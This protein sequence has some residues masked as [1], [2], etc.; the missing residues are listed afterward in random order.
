MFS[1]RSGG[2]PIRHA[3]FER[4]PDGGGPAQSRATLPITEKLLMK[5]PAMAGF[6]IMAA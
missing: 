2:L 1:P 4:P 3:A 6:L 5:G